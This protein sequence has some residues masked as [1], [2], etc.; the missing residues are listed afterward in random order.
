LADGLL[1]ELREETNLDGRLRRWVYISES[2]APDRS[3]HVVNL[4]GLVDTDD[5]KVAP[6]SDED[7]LVDVVWRPLTE[8]DGL[9]LY[10]DLKEAIRR[11]HQEGWNW[12]GAAY[13]DTPW[14]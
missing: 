2:I 1:R 11:G 13:V 10:P 7:I 12:Q 5:G 9:T 14:S 4:Y 3:K 6:G 8:L